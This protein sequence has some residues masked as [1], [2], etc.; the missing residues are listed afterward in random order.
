MDTIREGYMM[1]FIKVSSACSHRASDCGPP[2]LECCCGGSGGR[3]SCL[4]ACCTGKDPGHVC[5]LHTPWPA[6][7][8]AV[9][10]REIC[11]ACGGYAKFWLG[12][13]ESSEPGVLCLDLSC[14]R[15]EPTSRHITKDVRVR[16]E[17]GQASA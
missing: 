13:R 3:N 1:C 17:P 6:G 9:G 12:R 14:W 8:V 4:K 16:E 2:R 7:G 11:V 15:C 5:P 10:I